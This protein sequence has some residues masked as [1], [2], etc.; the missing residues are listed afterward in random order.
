MKSPVAQR[1][2]V[3][4]DL[5]KAKIG[6]MIALEPPVVVDLQARPGEIQTGANEQFVPLVVKRV[7]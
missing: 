3:E 7:S 2:Q 1:K 5:R 4:V 6:D